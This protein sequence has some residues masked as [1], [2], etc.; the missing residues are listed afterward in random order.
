MG[1]RDMTDAELVQ[2]TRCGEPVTRDQDHVYA[3]AY[4]LANN[5]AA[6]LMPGPGSQANLPHPAP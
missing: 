1:L 3:L 6:T 5:H 2:R 4:S